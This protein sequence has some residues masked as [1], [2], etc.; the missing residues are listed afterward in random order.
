[1]R[2]SNR[3]G[4]Q[5]QLNL[6]ILGSLLSVFSLI[7]IG[8]NSISYALETNTEF[9]SL[10]KI[11]TSFAEILP[12]PISPELEQSNEAGSK[13]YWTQTPLIED[14]LLGQPHEQQTLEELNAT[15]T[16]NFNP[17][18]VS[19]LK[20]K[21]LAQVSETTQIPIQRIEITGSTVFGDSEFNPLVEN[22]EGTTVTIEQ[23]RDL[24]NAITQLYLEEGFLTSKAVLL[25]DSLETGVVQIQIVEGT[26]EDV[27]VEG[28]QHLNPSY[29][30]E[31]IRLGAGKPLN[32]FQL[33]EQLRL[34]RFNPLFENIEATLQQGEQLNQSIVQVRV[35]EANPFY[36]NASIDNYSPPSIGS[37]RFN[38][39]LNYANLIG[40]GD[41]LRFG[42]TRTL[43][44]GSDAVDL[45]YLIPLNAMNGT[46]EL[47]TLFR[48]DE[49]I[50][51]PFEDLGI[52]GESQRY[53]ISYRQPLTR[54]L[55][56][57]F[58]L[59]F[60]FAFQEGQT[61][62]FAGPTPFG[63][64]PDEDGFSRTSVFKFGQD[65]IRRDS[66][67][68]WALRSQLNW[69][70]GLFDATINESP[71]P[72]GRFFS[73]L[74]Q[75][76]RVQQINP[77][78]VLIIQGDIHLTPN[79]LLPAQQFIIGGGQSVRGYRQ[80]LLAGDN[81][82][83]LSIE[84]RMTLTRD[85]A[86]D[87]TFQLALFLDAGAVIN[88]KNNPNSLSQNQNVIAGAGLGFLFTPL[89]QW[90]VR[91]DY[92]FSLVDI[93]NEGTNAQDEGFYFSVNYNF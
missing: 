62:T 12:S 29:I 37:E 56:E 84:D 17:F 11:P 1:M 25:E 93:D 82:V 16:S 54:T 67:G 10:G 43:A 14:K 70:T 8:N 86:G 46:L 38:L 88:T 35:E 66:S 32:T 53:E 75:V 57:E 58:A 30:R 60:G 42:Y 26:L 80:N 48:W 40:R 9:N 73:W 83:R 41:I 92:A 76:Q 71:I 69:G 36:G 74:G 33:E 89:P 50:Q 27:I 64:G 3:F 81:G 21:A 47:Q 22:L 77:A 13:D 20:E 7:S 63:F 18:S 34:L 87:P 52:R 51:D 79:T 23:L 85:E 6:K 61:F 44:G 90:D 15:K 4:G 78:N 24:A 19:D 65:Y 49:V 55:N 91:I 2:M 31:R 28:T 59:S 72:D 39:N 45:S 68:A 5:S